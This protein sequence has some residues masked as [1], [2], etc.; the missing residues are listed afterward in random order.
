[1]Q[2]FSI[3]VEMNSRTSAS[4]GPVPQNSGTRELRTRAM[5]EHDRVS[6]MRRAWVQKRIIGLRISGVRMTNA[7]I[8]SSVIAFMVFNGASDSGCGTSAEPFTSQSTTLDDLVVEYTVTLR[9]Q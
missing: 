2:A 6:C 7:R 4:T 5:S 3:S 1:M 8:E 9:V